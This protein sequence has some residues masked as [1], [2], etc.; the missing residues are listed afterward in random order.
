MAHECHNCEWPT[1]DDKTTTVFGTDATPEYVR[2][3]DTQITRCPNCKE[4]LE[5]TENTTQG[6]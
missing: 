6:I 2:L 3:G 4:T 1:E 5:T